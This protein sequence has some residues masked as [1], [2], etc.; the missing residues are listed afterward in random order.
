[1]SVSSEIPSKWTSL[2]EE[3][4]WWFL[5]TPDHQGPW[6]LPISLLDLAAV[7]ETDSFWKRLLLGEVKGF[8]LDTILP[9]EDMGKC[10]E[11]FEVVTQQC[12]HWSMQGRGSCQRPY[13][14]QDSAP[15]RELSARCVR[16]R[17]PGFVCLV[18]LFFP[19]SQL[20]L[21]FSQLPFLPP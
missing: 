5:V 3:I 13:G 6:P 10:L 19:H 1:M 16:L 17:I 11:T 18:L 20:L 4:S 12:Y 21:P 15:N 7:R 2:E 9:P 8:Q 14:A